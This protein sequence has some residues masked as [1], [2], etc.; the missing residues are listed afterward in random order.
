MA[1]LS[2]NESLV[3]GLSG[4]SVVLVEFH[5]DGHASESFVREGTNFGLRAL[6]SGLLGNVSEPEVVTITG[7]NQ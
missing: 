4:G 2:D 1:W 7:K 5:E 6:W 3:V